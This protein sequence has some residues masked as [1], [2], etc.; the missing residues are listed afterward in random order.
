MYWNSTDKTLNIVSDGMILQVGQETVIRSRNITGATI[1][2]AT[3][4]Y[5]NGADSNRP[6]IALA[7]ANA[8]YT[9]DVLGITT[10]PIADDAE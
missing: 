4:V 10:Q 5:I 1:A 9:S 6:T 7:Q 2:E 8:Y 3:V